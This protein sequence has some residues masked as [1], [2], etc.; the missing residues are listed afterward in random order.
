MESWNPPPPLPPGRWG[1]QFYWALGDLE[2]L[3]APGGTYPHG[4]F[5]IFHTFFW[6][7]GGNKVFWGDGGAPPPLAKNLLISLPPGKVP[8]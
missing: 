7:G 6:E 5:K 3:P 1:V 4:G 2:F 8:Q